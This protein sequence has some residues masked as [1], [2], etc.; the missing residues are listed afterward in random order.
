MSISLD[1]LLE[2]ADVDLN[3]NFWP[4]RQVPTKFDIFKRGER[5]GRGNENPIQRDQRNTELENRGTK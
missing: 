4:P 3:N 2:T 5:G 1:P